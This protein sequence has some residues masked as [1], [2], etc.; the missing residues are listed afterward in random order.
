MRHVCQYCGD[1]VDPSRYLKE[2]C[3]IKHYCSE[4]HKNRAERLR[5]G[6]RKPRSAPLKLDEVDRAYLEK[7]KK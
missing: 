3:L 2:N 6:L 5:Y 1:E 7:M 4:R